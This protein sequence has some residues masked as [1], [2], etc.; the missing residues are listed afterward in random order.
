[1]PAAALSVKERGNKAFSE[2]QFALAIDEYTNAIKLAP[3]YAPLYSNRAAAY[4]RLN[5]LPKALQDAKEATDIDERWAK[6]WMRLGEVML[7]IGETETD[8]VGLKLMYGAVQE[9]YENAYGLLQ[10]EGKSTINQREGL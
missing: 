7:A 9:T 5:Q 6:G 2:G 10:R 3:N 8:P 1:M 4:L